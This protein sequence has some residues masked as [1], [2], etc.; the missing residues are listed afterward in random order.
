MKFLDRRG[1]RNN[2]LRYASCA[3]IIITVV[4]IIRQLDRDALRKHIKS[5]AKKPSTFSE[6]IE[7]CSNKKLT[8]MDG[9]EIHLPFNFRKTRKERP[10]NNQ[11]VVGLVSVPGSGNTWMRYLLQQATGNVL[12]HS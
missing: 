4:L 10:L 5:L 2:F 6:P 7:W 1:F 8:F 12:A 9:S 3:I 11:G